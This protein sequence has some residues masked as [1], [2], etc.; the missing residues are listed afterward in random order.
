MKSRR[1]FVVAILLVAIMCMGVGFA[2]LDSVIN[3]TGTITYGPTFQI[4]WDGATAES[5]KTTDVSDIVG[6][7]EE[8]S[9]KVNTSSWAISDS[10]TITA[11]VKNDLK[12]AAKNVEVQGLTTTAVDDYYDVTVELENDAT[13]I[14]AD[15]TL[16]VIITITMTEYP[17]VDETGFNAN[18]TFKV[19]AKQ[20]V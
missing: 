15:G 10:V 11:T 14:A 1:N 4:A 18:F 5:G 2:A 12:Y 6:T 3:G 9:F 8:L 20:D 16:N 19:Y 13:T 7:G 17:Q